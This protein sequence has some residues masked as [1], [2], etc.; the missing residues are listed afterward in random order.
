VVERQSTDGPDEPQGDE[1]PPVGLPVPRLSGR[2]RYAVVIGFSTLLVV[3]VFVLVGRVAG[4]T[5]TLDSLKDANPVWLAV[6]FGSQVVSYSAY[7]ALFRAFAALGRGPRVP[8]WLAARVVF[9][10]LGATRLL[11]AAGAGGLAVFYWAL[12]QLGLARDAAV[13]RVF[14]IN[15]ALYA[16]FGAAAFIAALALLVGLGEDVPLAMTL[17]WIAGIALIAVV[18]VALTRPERAGRLIAAGEKGGPVRQ[19]AGQAVEGARLTRS[20][21]EE[22]RANQATLLA[23]PLYWAGDMACLWA[24]LQA[25]DVS[26]SP[27]AIVLAYATGFLANMVPLPTGGIG[28]VDAATTFALTAVGVP[29]SSALLGVFTYRFFSF[30]LPTLPAVVAVPA[31]PRVGR[32]LRELATVRP[33]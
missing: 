24:G 29:L 27:Q 14:A 31:L 6:C 17:P 15:T 4:Y 23:A 8:S 1:A 18:G 12:R 28:G 16:T 21:A 11:A 32:E 13:V 30:L 3:G 19:I 10:A 7:V 26:L 20:L 5:K 2:L 22:P 25:F 9:A 33:S